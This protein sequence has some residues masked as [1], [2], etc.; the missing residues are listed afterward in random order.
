MTLVCPGRA[1]WR[2]DAVTARHLELVFMLAWLLLKDLLQNL[3]SSHY[4]SAATQTQV[5]IAHTY[6]R[7][8]THGQ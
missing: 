5:S 3:K 7:T 8:R 1:R 6:T 2:V 4:G